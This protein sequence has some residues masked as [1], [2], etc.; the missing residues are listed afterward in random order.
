M[1]RDLVHLIK[2][3]I[4]MLDLAVATDIP[5]FDEVIHTSRS[6]T[7]SIWMEADGGYSHVVILESLNAVLR[8]YIPK[9]NCAIS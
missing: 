4:I 7:G 9:L 2:S 5:D 6:Y 3:C 1:E 8:S